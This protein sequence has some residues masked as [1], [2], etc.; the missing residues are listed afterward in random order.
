[1]FS[2]RVLSAF[3]AAACVL[4]A[5]TVPASAAGTVTVDNRLQACVV[6]QAGTRTAERGLLLQEITLDVRKPIG[7]CGCKSAV[8]GYASRV[9]L[10]GGARSLL[11]QGRLNARQS[12]PRSLPL[13]SDAT[14]V[15]DRPIALSFECAAPD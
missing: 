10:E 15:G 2:H 6:I 8:M 7:E 1:M 5:G 11:L 14:L 9:V 3:A 13:A 12:G 4:L